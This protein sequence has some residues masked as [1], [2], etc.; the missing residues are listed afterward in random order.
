[1]GNPNNRDWLR[2][3]TLDKRVLAWHRNRSNLLM[4]INQ[5]CDRL[6]AKN[7]LD[8]EEA[9]STIKA[10]RA[11][12]AAALAQ[13][14]PQQ[15]AMTTTKCPEITRAAAEI[16][17]QMSELSKCWCTKC[18]PITLEDMRF[19]VCPDCGNKRCPRAHNHTLA[20]TKSN[21]VGQPGSSWEHIK[22]E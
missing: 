11:A 3:R 17:K 9:V 1:M 20:C 22:G 6:R 2:R 18:R 13:P 21:D 8:C 4:E 7:D 14:V 5:L 19:V 16:G 15:A 10:L 12:L